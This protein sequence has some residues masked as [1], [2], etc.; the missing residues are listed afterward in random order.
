MGLDAVC[1][2]LDVS[3]NVSSPSR[4]MGKRIVENHY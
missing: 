2:G 3:S 4:D 1:V